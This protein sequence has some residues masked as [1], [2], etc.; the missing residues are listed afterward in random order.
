MQTTTS[1]EG[2]KCVNVDEDAMNN[3]VLSIDQAMDTGDVEN[4]CAFLTAFGG[5]F[6]DEAGR[7]ARELVVTI[8]NELITIQVRADALE[9]RRVLVM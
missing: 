4:C 3:D 5:V 6:S 8:A 9:S 2:D 7:K 1:P